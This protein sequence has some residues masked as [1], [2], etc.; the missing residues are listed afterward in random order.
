L[1]KLSITKLQN[2]L[3]IDTINNIM[4]TLNDF[5]DIKLDSRYIVKLIKKNSNDQELGRLIREYYNYLKEAK[6]SEE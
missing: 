5:K 3:T 4:E 6:E 2:N 1:G